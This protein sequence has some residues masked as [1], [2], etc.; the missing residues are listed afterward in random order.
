MDVCKNLKINPCVKDKLK[1]KGSVASL[2]INYV[3]FKSEGLK[4]KMLIRFG[5][6]FSA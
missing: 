2:W 5:N 1:A 6:I 4:F 3:L